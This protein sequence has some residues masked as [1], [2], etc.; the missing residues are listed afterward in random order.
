M[1]KFVI[2]YK[3]NCFVLFKV[4]GAL[5][6]VKGHVTCVKENRHDIIVYFQLNDIIISIIKSFM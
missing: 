5:V 1:L 4:H 3:K 6:F 2:K